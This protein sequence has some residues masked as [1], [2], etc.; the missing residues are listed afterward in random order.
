MTLLTHDA[1]SKSGK[2]TQEGSW[3]CRSGQHMKAVSTF[4]FS[5]Q[6]NVASFTMHQTAPHQPTLMRNILGGNQAECHLT[7]TQ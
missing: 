7:H 5:T 6:T 1:R 2:F 3:D 4:D